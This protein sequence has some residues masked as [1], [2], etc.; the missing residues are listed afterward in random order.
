MANQFPIGGLSGI[1]LSALVNGLRNRVFS[2]G[3][4]ITADLDGL[5]YTPLES[6]VITS[7]NGGSGDDSLIAASGDDQITLSLGDLSTMVSRAAAPVDPGAVTNIL[8]TIGASLPSGGATGGAGDPL[9]S[10]DL[11]PT[12][13]VNQFRFSDG[14]IQPL[15]HTG[16]F[17]PGGSVTD[18]ISPGVACAKA[19][20]AASGNKTVFVNM[21][22]GGTNMFGGLRNHNVDGVGP[23]YDIGGSSDDVNEDGALYLGVENV[24]TAVKAAIEAA[25]E[26]VGEIRIYGNPGC[27]EN[28]AGTAENETAPGTD[29][30]LI[31]EGIRYVNGVR[32]Q[33]ESALGG[34]KGTSALWVMPGSVPEWAYVGSVSQIRMNAAYRHIAE[35]VPYAA[36]F[37]GPDGYQDASAA[38]HYSN[39][40]SRVI[41]AMGYDAFAVAATR[42]AAP[43]IPLVDALDG[44]GLS[45][46]TFLYRTVSAYGTGNSIRVVNS[47]SDEAD[48]PFLE[49]GL[50]DLAA[51][52]THAK[53]GNGNADVVQTYDALGTGTDASGDYDASVGSNPAR[54]MTG[55]V[56]HCQG[57]RYAWGNGG[58]NIG[59]TAADSY[60]QTSA[61][62]VVAIGLAPDAGNSTIVGG[63][64]NTLAIVASS[65]N[66]IARQ[67]G[68][69]IT[70]DA[71]PAVD[72]AFANEGYAYH[73]YGLDAADLYIDGEVAAA[74]AGGSP[75]YSGA[76]IS[77]GSKPDGTR[78]VAAA[79]TGLLAWDVAPAGATLATV[80]AA[81]SAFVAP[82]DMA[83]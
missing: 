22:V 80:N 32:A 20:S 28:D 50:L 1:R 49:N 14:T 83:V 27:N 54:I 70:A 45:R 5:P 37:E 26:A 42:A 41:G 23:A 77:I 16:Y 4:T 62:M 53:L 74:T 71:F 59:M 65:G 33:I 39:V 10:D 64:T 38:I 7:D 47:L 3:D 73:S 9:T 82:D 2:S 30:L 55:G 79:W 43:G 21:A 17:R 40:G 58:N 57:N 35:L 36:F 15:S 48:I 34:G 69:S 78:S 76:T 24:V 72:P 61:G 44:T 67:G 25:G 19:W 68:S 56:V 52:Y 75:N 29:A 60:A 66:L 11:D 63:P 18:G 46:S 13:Q 12:G 6:V 81:L 31:S 8:L 51:L